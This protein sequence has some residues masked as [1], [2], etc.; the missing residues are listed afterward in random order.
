M[1]LSVIRASALI[2]ALLWSSHASAAQIGL[3]SQ[4]APNPTDYVLGVGPGADFMPMT[5]S[6][7]GDVSG[8]LWP[9]NDLMI[10]PTPVPTSNSGC[11]AADFAGFLPGTIAL[12]QRGTCTF[13]DK[14]ANA[15]AAGAFGVLIFNEGQPGRTDSESFALLS[16]SAIP[17]AAISFDLGLALY[18]QIFSGTPVTIRLQVTD[19]SPELPEPASLVLLGTGA[20]GLFASAR[21]RR[22]RLRQDPASLLS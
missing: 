3:L 1:G 12:I 2:V 13:V 5:L 6:A 11:E 19:S 18:N 8:L 15:A 17:V 14:V 10:P 7:L 9:V 16:P 21:H 4:L 22:R 20:V